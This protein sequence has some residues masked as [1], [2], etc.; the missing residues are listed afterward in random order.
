MPCVFVRFLHGTWPAGFRVWLVVWFID[1]K[2][3]SHHR[4]RLFEMVIPKTYAQWRHCITVD[5]GLAL[6]VAFIEQRLAAWLAEE[7]EEV[8]RFRRLYGDAH[9]LAVVA[10]FEQAQQEILAA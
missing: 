2:R 5:C 3:P 1:S 10:W 9:W 7:S 4:R 6:T 8:Q